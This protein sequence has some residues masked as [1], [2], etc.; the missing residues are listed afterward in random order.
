MT[1]AIQDHPGVEHIERL[2][3]GGAPSPMAADLL[4][5][6]GVIDPARA[7]RNLQ[8][9]ALHPAFPRNDRDF[10][11]QLLAAL[12][13]TFEPERALSNFERIMATREDPDALLRLLRRYPER[14][15]ALFTLAGGSQFLTDTVLRHPEFLDWLLRP[16]ALQGERSESRMEAELWRWVQRLRTQPNGPSN[17]LRRF[18]QREYLRI[19]LR[20]LM[21]LADMPQTVL[22]L[23][24]LADATLEA[25]VR[26]ARA[27]LEARYGKPLYR[28]KEGRS[29]P[30]EFA[31]IA[32]GKLGGLELNFSSDIDL[33]FIYSSDEGGTRGATGRDHISN[34]EFHARLARRVI[35]LMAENTEEG[36]VFRV[37]TRLRPEGDQGALAYSLRS[38]EVYYESWGETWE[39]QALIKARLAAG[40]AALGKAFLDMI[41]PFIYRR[42]LDLSALDEIGHIKDR[43]NA[44]IAASG[45]KASNIKLGEGGIREIE[46]IV[47]SFQLI[48][49]GKEKFLRTP[50]TLEALSVIQALGLLPMDDCAALSSAYIFLRDIEHRVQMTQGLQTHDLPADAHALTV[51]ARKMGFHR[52]GGMSERT[53]FLAA[54]QNHQ[55]QVSRVFQNLFR[56]GDSEEAGRPAEEEAPAA[57]ETLEDSLAPADLAPYNFADPESASARLR[58]LRNGE[59]FERVSAR[60]KRLFDNLLPRLLFLTLDLPDPDQAVVNLS[61]FVERSGGREGAFTLLSEQENVLEALLRLFGSSDYL[62]E[63]L[64]SQPGLLDSL[65]QAEALTSSKAAGTLQKELS[66][67]ALKGSDAAQRFARLC[68][69]KR[70]EELAI[71]LRSILGEA[72]I[73]QTMSDL[74]SLAEAVLAV[75]LRVAEEEVRGLHGSPIEA[76]TGQPAGFSIIGLGKLG[77]R[78]MN[79]GSDLDLVFV[80]SGPGGTDG[81]INGKGAA[82]GSASNHQ[83]F[84]RL[85]TALR[86]GLSAPASGERAYEIDLRLRP[87]GQKGAIAVPLQ[88]FEDYFR[89]RAELWERQAL[90]RA[91][92]VAGSPALSRRFMGLAAEFVYER[93]LPPNLAAGIDHV[94]LRMERELTHEAEGEIDLKLG[95]GGLTDIEFLV[96]YLLISHGR[97]KPAIRRPE[98]A[99]ALR[100]LRAAGLLNEED[101]DTLLDTYRFLRQVEN[102]L[103]IARAQPLHT[104]PAT[105]EGMEMLARRLGYSDDEEGSSRAKLLADYERHTQ[106]VRAIYRER[107]GLKKRA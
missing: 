63:S 101:A 80:Y 75:G 44:Q 86:D 103:R 95:H 22:A 18:R 71:G 94:R 12:S 104:F 21:R 10:L 91:R 7:C 87:E 14:R 51:L 48:Y 47:Q 31:V 1:V 90:C 25:A 8:S 32:L 62:S 77:S 100:A 82:W 65:F 78:E 106:R 97:E 55:D 13:E 39:R 69:A 19:G 41:R 85:A 66:A 36:H 99:E 68:A 61:R 49:G 2:L 84:L 3:A 92:P 43:I 46:F 67:E 15:A 107:L 60:A 73:F 72:D 79:F 23:S 30:C 33:I 89:D 34:H 83:F 27:E 50:S 105:P 96:Q 57:A 16:S 52:T 9:L 20:D 5:S 59:P 102:R 35:A 26:V 37:D 74:T 29:L 76:E 56:K 28:S 6:I 53:G 81:K 64:L 88:T 42:T 4:D 40:S 11:V 17:A 38:C 58:L 54:L 98:T 93:P 70:G 24:H 45:R